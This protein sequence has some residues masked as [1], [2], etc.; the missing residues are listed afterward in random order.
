M[1]FWITSL[2]IV[3]STVHL[4]ADQRKHQSPASLA[5]VRGIHRWPVNSPHKGTVTRKC[6]HFMT[7]SWPIVRFDVLYFVLV[8]LSSLGLYSLRHRVIC[9]GIP[10]ISLRRSPDSPGLMMGIALSVWQRSF[11]EKKWIHAIPIPTFFSIDSQFPV[12]HK[13]ILNNI[14]IKFSAVVEID[15]NFRFSAMMMTNN[16]KKEWIMM[17]RRKRLIK[18]GNKNI[19]KKKYFSPKIY[20]EHNM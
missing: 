1:A 8:S 15:L 10:I 17:L 19:S 6:V 4:G 5:F 3:Y 14:D 2:A 7:S 12:F 9:L 11:S 18:K 13:V 20:C 16:K